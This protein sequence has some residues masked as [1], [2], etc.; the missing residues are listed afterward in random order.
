M[1]KDQ[2]MLFLLIQA[3]PAFW[4]TWIWILRIPTFPCLDPKIPDFHKFLNFQISNRPGGGWA[5]GQSV[6]R[7]VGMVVSLQAIP[8]DVPLPFV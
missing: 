5:I 2:D 6:G 7:A 3:L 8:M 1:K 4:V